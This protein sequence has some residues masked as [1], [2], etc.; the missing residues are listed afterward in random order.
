MRARIVRFNAITGD[1]ISFNQAFLAR[2]DLK[3]ILN[4]RVSF[5]FRGYN[6]YFESTLSSYGHTLIPSIRSSIVIDNNDT[7]L[8]PLLLF[9][10]YGASAVDL[11]SFI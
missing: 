4:L 7:G 3:F 10:N 1:I 6:Y 11:N 8:S 5:F 9:C 2:C